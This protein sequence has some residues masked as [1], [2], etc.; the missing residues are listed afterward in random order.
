MQN[1]LILASQHD[2]RLLLLL[3]KKPIPKIISGRMRTE[4]YLF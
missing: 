3:W 2:F 4:K 1:R